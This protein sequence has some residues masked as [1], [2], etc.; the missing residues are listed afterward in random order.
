GPDAAEVVRELIA[1]G[2]IER[3][4][5]G[6]RLRSLKGT[7][8]DRGVLVN[9]VERGTEAEK[10]GLRPGDRILSLDGIDVDAPQPVD[11]PALQ[12][13]IGSKVVLEIDRRGRPERITLTARAQPQD[14]GEERAFAP[15]GASLV[16]L[17]P[18]MSRRRQL[19]ADSGLLVT[20]IRPGG[21]AAIAR[22][23]LQAGDVIRAVNGKTVSV[24]ADLERYVQAGS[25]EGPLVIEF[26]RNAE[27][28][29]AVLTP[30]H[31]D[32]VRTPLPSLPKAW[33]GV[34]VQPITSSLARDLGLPGPGYRITRLYPGSP[35]GNA[36]ARVGDLLTG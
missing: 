5:L 13:R 28:R 21:P 16:E 27:R 30:V 36:G 18:A 8:Y 3:A 17:T 2:R 11:V 19:E 20:G 9:A 15:F 34:E 6:F 7:G 32:R 35:L 22:P 24:H 25:G 14:R 12:R 33:A 29:L 4:H 1:H 23:A 31:G 10:A 26:Q